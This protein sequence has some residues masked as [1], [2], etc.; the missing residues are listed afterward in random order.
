[1]DEPAPVN[2]PFRGVV[3]A[4]GLMALMTCCCLVSINAFWYFLAY[5]GL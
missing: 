1:M 5:G 3:V 2:G 4:L